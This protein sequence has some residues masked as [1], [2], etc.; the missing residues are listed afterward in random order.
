MGETVTGDQAPEP[1]LRR[2]RELRLGLLR[3]HKTLLNAERAVYERVYGQVTGG[4]LLQLIIG[5]EHFAWLHTISELIVRMDEMLEAEEPTAGE[6]QSLFAR[7]RATLN[8]SEEGD[9]FRRKYFAALQRDP[10]AVLAH[11]RVTQILFADT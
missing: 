4:E 5:D 7:A 6:A 1:L 2:T 3:L 9:E 8:P 10:D 11:R